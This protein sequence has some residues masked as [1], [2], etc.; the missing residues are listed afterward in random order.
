MIDIKFR[1]WFEEE[2]RMIEWEQL[3]LENDDCGL[4][5][6]IGEDG[7]N[8]GTASAYPIDDFKVMQYTGLEDKNGKE[9]FEGDIVKYDSVRTERISFDN[10]QFTSGNDRG[11]THFS[12]G[13][14]D[15]CE[16]IGNIYENPEL[17]HKQN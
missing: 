16:I 11:S 7:N 3:H 14:A 17:L 5:V 8:F 10:A 1:A 15:I 2:N 4:I 9:V 13:L 6:W 12:K